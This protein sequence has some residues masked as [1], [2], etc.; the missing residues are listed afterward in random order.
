MKRLKF[1]LQFQMSTFPKHV[2]FVGAATQKSVDKLEIV[3]QKNRLDVAYEWMNLIW[4]YFRK[5]LV[6]VF[7]ASTKSTNGNYEK[8]GWGSWRVSGCFY[9][10]CCQR[11]IYIDLES[12]G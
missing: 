12:R 8:N 1:I 2:V 5:N 10:H 6:I 11:W 4:F 3:I 7:Y 9:Q